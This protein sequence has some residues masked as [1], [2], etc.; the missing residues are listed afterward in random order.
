MHRMYEIT[1]FV[2]VKNNTNKNI[3]IPIYRI[4]KGWMECKILPDKWNQNNILIA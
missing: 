4:S 1:E 2:S 3:T